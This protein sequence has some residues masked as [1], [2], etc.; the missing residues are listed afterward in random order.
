MQRINK[1]NTTIF[2]SCQDVRASF[3]IAT[4]IKVNNIRRVNTQRTARI[5][6]CALRRIRCLWWWK[7]RSQWI[8]RE[9][10]NQRIISSDAHLLSFSLK[11][12]FVLMI[13]EISDW[14]TNYSKFGHPFKSKK[15]SFIFTWLSILLSYSRPIFFYTNVLSNADNEMN[16]FKSIRLFQQ[17][18][19]FSI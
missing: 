10:H 19:I 5:F 3:K 8:W 13:P 12:S 4:T 16:T 6:F 17:Q 9:Q 11:L 15:K 2:L 7:I 18:M 14:T 1:W